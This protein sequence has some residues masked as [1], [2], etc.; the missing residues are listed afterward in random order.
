MVKM[1]DLVIKGG[2]IVSGG[3]TTPP[4]WIAV[5]SG[6]IVAIGTDGNQPQAKI[7]V[8]ASGKY[9]IPGVIDP[10]QHSIHPFEENILIES[11]ASVASGVTT[12][13]V[14]SPSLCIT[15]APKGVRSRMEL[16]RPKGPEEVPSF[17]ESIPRFIKI[18]SG[19]MM[20]DWF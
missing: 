6:K 10:E 20:T 13:G 1:V 4:A 5:D 17:M 9:V 2:R 15:P 18:A 12:I 11:R 19:R 8:D 7:T 3:H 16:P 14:M